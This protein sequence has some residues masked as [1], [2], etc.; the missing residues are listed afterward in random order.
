MLRGKKNWILALIAGFVMLSCQ[1]EEE[2][3]VIKEAELKTR[4]ALLV[5]EGFH[6]GEAFMPM[7]YL[8]NKGYDVTVIGAEVGEVKA[9]NSDFTINIE[10]SVADVKPQDFEALVLPGGQGPAILREDEKVIDFVRKFWETGKVTAA[11]CHGPQVLI[12]AGVMD[13]KT[14]TGIGGIRE[15]L[16]EAGVHFKD[17]S[18]VIDDNLITSRFPD[19][20]YDFSKTIDQ[21]IQRRLINLRL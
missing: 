6:D 12:T 20:L 14:S 8:I 17:E 15:E 16:E 18:V 7:A 19:D 5:A 11:I 10:K 13:G 21:E 9:Y 1:S 3:T 4:V 2:K